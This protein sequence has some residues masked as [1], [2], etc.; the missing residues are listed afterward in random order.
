MNKLKVK[1][2]TLEN[3]KK[4]GTFVNMINPDACKMGNEPVEFFRDMITL[5]FA[6]SNTGSF[7]ICRVQKRPLLINCLEYHTNVGEGALPLDGDVFLTVAPATAGGDVPLDKIEV[8][9][10]P[11]GTFVTI[12]PGVWHSAPFSVNS[13]CVN[14]VI[15]LPERTYA[16]D[17]S[18]L[19]IN[20]EKF[21]EIE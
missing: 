19:T 10:V 4:F 5:N 17:C 14:V 8:F 12:L 3:F 16:N 11:K 15:I 7:S 21:F 2:L 9:F 6:Q 1:K 18:F 13:D 20:E